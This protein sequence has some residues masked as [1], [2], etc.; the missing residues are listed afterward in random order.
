MPLHIR[1]ARRGFTLVELLV[2]IA[3]IGMLVTL[4]L[5]A[6]QS[7]RE[8][9]RRA[10]CAN[11]LR[12]HGIALNNYHDAY[13]RFPPAGINYGWCRN[14]PPATNLPENRI[15]NVNGIL[16]MAP[17]LEL[18][19]ALSNYNPS[20]AASDVNVGNDN[21]CSP[22]QAQ[23][24]LSGTVAGT[25]AT[26][27]AAQFKVFSCPSDTGDPR[28]PTTGVYSI[29]MGSNRGAGAKTNYD[30]SAW[31][32]SYVCKHWATHTL[33]Q[34]RMFGE[35]STARF[36]DVID[37]SSHTVAFCETTNDVYNGRAPAWG[38]RG[39]VMVGVDIGSSAGINNWTYGTYITFT[40]GPDWRENPRVGRLGSWAYPGSLHPGGCQVCMADG[41]VRFVA[42]NTDL[43]IRER[44]AAMADGNT[45]ILP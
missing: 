11:N 34:R 42:Q 22:T 10:S 35:N 41:S 40:Q 27:V 6:V 45:V 16:L 18:G 29:G 2:V 13:K 32:G 26:L 1:A 25:N 31:S 21:C 36:S 8:A 33:N 30:F 20:A 44:M 15:Y 14:P 24:P 39:W 5:P 23:E 17:F 19:G 12:Q 28:L 37:G 43:T 4:L 38:Y 9:A 7:A 3:I